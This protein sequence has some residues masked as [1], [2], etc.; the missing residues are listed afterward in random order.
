MHAGCSI[1]I[2]QKSYAKYFAYFYD[3]FI[4]YK[5]VGHCDDYE[6]YRCCVRLQPNTKNLAIR[7]SNSNIYIRIKDARLRML[8]IFNRKKNA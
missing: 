5:Y 3:I 4:G 8:I 2:S 6:R 1:L 7:I